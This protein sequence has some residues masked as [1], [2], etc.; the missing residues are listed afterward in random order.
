MPAISK[1]KFILSIYSF[2]TFICYHQYTQR[3][4]PTNNNNNNN[5]NYGF[6]DAFTLKMGLLK[7]GIPQPWPK[8]KKNLRYVR[9]AGVR[10]FISHYNRVKNLKGDELLW[11]DEIE[12]GIFHL[13][14]KNKKIRLSLRAKEVRQIFECFK[15]KGYFLSYFIV[16]LILLLL[17][18]KD[19]G[20]SE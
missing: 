20:S 5:N 14:E 12:Y 11:G 9:K 6:C 4:S 7:V 2:I 8:S 19:Y 10:Q 17:D 15:D 3:Y 16:L 13:D 1:P 18:F